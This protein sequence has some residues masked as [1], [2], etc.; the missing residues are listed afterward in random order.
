MP[1]DALE[2]SPEER[3][4]GLPLALRAAFARVRAVVLDVDGVLTDGRVDVTHGGS[5]LVSQS[6]SFSIR[7]GSGLWLLRKA[8]LHIGLI[9][10]RSTSVP[11]H[12]SDAFPF[13]ELVSGCRAK[14]AALETMAAGWGLSALECA[15]VG[16][17]LID[18]PAVVAAG[19]GVAVADAAR[20]LRTAADFVTTARGGHGAVREVAELVLAARG[21]REP[22]VARFLPAAGAPGS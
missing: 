7:D 11:E 14:G 17:D 6:M 3:I 5:G 21:E 22:Q 12:L 2:P 4:A 18:G 20:D 15:Y 13:D 10:G 19:L 16:D 1:S 9:T 8:G